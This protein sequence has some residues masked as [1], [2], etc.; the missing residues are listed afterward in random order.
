MRGLH[1]APSEIRRRC[2]PVGRDE[3]D[4]REPFITKKFLRC[5]EYS[6][7]FDIGT[8]RDENYANS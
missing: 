2:F 4:F 6:D 1:Q 5:R 3:L 8:F 7:A